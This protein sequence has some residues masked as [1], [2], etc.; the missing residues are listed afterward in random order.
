MVHSRPSGD[1]LR[2]RHPTAY[3][4]GSR[5]PSGLR[6]TLLRCVSHRKT[7]PTSKDRPGGDPTVRIQSAFNTEIVDRLQWRAPAYVVG[8]WHPGFAVYHEDLPGVV[9][10][11]SSRR[12][13][14]RPSRINPRWTASRI[15]AH[16]CRRVTEL[17]RTTATFKGQEAYEMNSGPTLTTRYEPSHPLSHH[18]REISIAQSVRDVP[19]HAQFN[20][21]ALE[22]PSAVDRVARYRLGHSGTP[23]AATP[24]SR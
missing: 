4:V 14:C 6:P 24:D 12:M 3:I 9:F 19:A 18:G 23:G 11:T 8:S 21:L 15:F 10:A 7:G 22:S 1:P 2:L 20:D 17:L 13:V 5:S 16:A